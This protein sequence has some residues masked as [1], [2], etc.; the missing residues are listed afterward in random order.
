MKHFFYFL[1]FIAE[2]WFFKAPF[3]FFRKE[4]KDPIINL[5]ILFPDESN[6]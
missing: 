4:R 5:F 3:F 2:P 6:R 1:L